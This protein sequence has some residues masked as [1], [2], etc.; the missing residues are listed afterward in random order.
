MNGGDQ[1]T[2]KGFELI[3][4]VLARVVDKAEDSAALEREK[5]Q[6]RTERDRLDAEVREREA[7]ERDLADAQRRA[8]SLRAQVPTRYRTASLASWQ[9]HGTV[10]DQKIQRRVLNAALAYDAMFGERE[11][12]ATYFPQ[13]T[14]FQGSPGTGK[15]HIA[16]SLVASAHVVH[17][18]SFVF[19][20][21]Q[22]LVRDIRGAWA[23]STRDASDESSSEARRV[24][25]YR[26]TG[27]LV[28]DEVSRDK[29][30]VDPTKHLYDVVADREEWMRPTIL[31]TNDE[32]GTFFKLIGDSLAD[33]LKGSSDLWNFGTRS[34]RPNLRRPPNP[35]A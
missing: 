30:T 29:L 32:E 6:L 15:N 24:W 19:C 5:E 23:T 14:A 21:A 10:A 1:G 33:R 13:L 26:T 9:L 12:P 3:R 28:I 16:W 31:I 4:A 34:Y 18:A 20:R 25:R 35:E 27:L 11:N 8:D 17:N 7:A 22:D 2:P